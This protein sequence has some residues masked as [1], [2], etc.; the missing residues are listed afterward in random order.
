[1]GVYD[2]RLRV[3]V[4]PF[5][6]TPV[7]YGFPSNVDAAVATACGHQQITGDVVG[8]VFG[9]N[10]PKPGRASRKNAAG[11]SQ[12]SFY[13]FAVYF[14]LIEDGWSVSLPKRKR[15]GTTARGRSVYVTVNGIKYAWNMTN[16]QAQ[17]IGDLAGLGIEQ[18][19]NNDTDLVFG[20]SQPKP[21]SARKV[22]VGEGGTDVISTFVDPTRADNLPEGWSLTNEV[23]PIG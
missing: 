13:D 1:M 12:S 20:A 7:K 11:E 15:G 21:P 6:G 18:A 22:E 9:A 10:S 19:T 4:E 16:R 3:F 5:Q 23:V 17:R 14:Q 8:L 2:D